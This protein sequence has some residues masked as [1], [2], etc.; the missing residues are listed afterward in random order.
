MH[1]LRIAFSSNNKDS[2]LSQEKFNTVV[3]TVI[4]KLGSSAWDQFSKPFGDNIRLASNK[5]TTCEDGTF[6]AFL[7]M[8]MRWFN[9]VSDMFADFEE[10]KACNN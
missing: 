3:C 6:T 5:H 1:I 4:A 9:S 8:M 7:E 10:K 2:S